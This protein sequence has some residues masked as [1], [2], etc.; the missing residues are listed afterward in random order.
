MVEVPVWR[1]AI[2][3]YPH[4]LLERGLIVVDT[5]GLNAIGAEPELTLGLLPSAHAA[6]FVLGADTGV[7]RSDLD[8]W[9]AHLGARALERFVV[10]N[11]ID[12]LADPLARAEEV[13]FQIEHQRQQTAAT[14]GIGIE[15]IFPLSARD[16]LAARLSG[17]VKGLVASRLPDLEAALS[18]GLLPR[19]HE[20][21]SQA[22]CEIVAG[23]RQSALRRLADRRR[24]N[25]EEMLELRG[26]RGKSGGKVRLMLGRVE[27]EMADFE[28]CTARLA[29]L[30]V[31]QA[32]MLRAATQP[33]G[34][35][36]LRHAVAGLP[37][38]S[39]L[40]LL[41]MSAA[42]E[43][44]CAELKRGLEG[45][46]A[47]TAEM[48]QMVQASFD[49]L[50]AEFGFS[51]ACTPA[52]DLEPAWR[53][54]DRIERS[55]GR[56][57]GLTQAWRLT[58]PGAMEQ[59]RRMLLSKL[60]VLFENATGELDLWSKSIT[61]QVELQLRERRKGFKRRH[62]ALER[63]QQAAGELET[64]IGELEEQ[65]QRLRDLQQRL[66]SLADGAEAAARAL[67]EAVLRRDAA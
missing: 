3:R 23:V 58:L 53:E 45:T 14:L 62:E 25:A 33:M 7:T 12:T 15:R 16:A 65:E 2:I 48:Q 37:A 27:S 29:A 40:K 56:F 11:K 20:L 22:A 43:R 47:Q 57:L 52:P 66:Q 1:H 17:D 21:L 44:F 46:R 39:G 42:F 55:Y 19:Q 13:A 54:L 9:R 51:F 67:P 10:L 28:R 6:V 18:A 60:R 50:N 41:T 30:R 59:F 35:E 5:P 32:K 8:V 64:R 4:A 36:A 63:I 49:Q 24:Q 31:V 61:S 38:P 26:L 34:G